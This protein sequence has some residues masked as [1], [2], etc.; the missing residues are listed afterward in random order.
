MK[1][2]FTILAICCIIST[3][4]SQFQF[5]S[6]IV[7]KPL[8]EFPDV[9]DLST[10]LNAGVTISYFLVNGIDYPWDNEM[11]KLYPEHKREKEINHR[12]V[13]ESVKQRLLNDT[14]K[15]V[16]VYKDSIA[17]MIKK[18]TSDYYLTWW[19]TYEDGRW[20][21]DGEDGCR[22][23]EYERERF[24]TNAP[25]ALARNHRSNELKI[26][27]TDTLSFV[28]YVKQHGTEPKEFLLETLSQ[29]PLVIYGEYHRRK[30][31][32]DLLSSLL[33]D[34]RFPEIVG[35]VF[36]EMP[37]Y[38]QDEFDRFYASEK[39]DTE[40]VLD[41]MRSF[42]INGWLDKGEYDFFVN[43]WKLNQTLP[44]E[45]RIR[46]VPTDEQPPWKLLNTKE[47][48]DKW[49]ENFMDRNTRMADVVENTL[50]TKTDRRNCLFVVGYGHAYKSHFPG[51]Q[52]TLKG[53]EPAL[54]AGAQ[55]AQR[56][57]GEKVFTI[58]QHTPIGN[59]NGYLPGL[60]RQGLF[61]YVFEINGN[62]PVAFP[63]VNSPFG[64]EPYDADY[65]MC[66]DR[67]VGNFEDNFDGYI[68]LQP[69]KDEEG[70]YILYEEI[71]SDTFVDE[72][73]RRLAFINRD[74][75]RWFGIEGEITKEKI[76]KVFK[77]DEGKKRWGYLFE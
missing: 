38:Q 63:L 14:I 24:N 5:Q 43:L 59:N 3:L 45:K 20:L 73:K 55:L 49:E 6:I 50:K 39:L 44:I 52:S 11:I 72:L 32:W 34:P 28:N 41:I 7:N 61:D 31:S 21:Y 53:Q 37:A 47:D 19:F 8:K 60:I 65:D 48:F 29:Y 46:V 62:K 12:V 16:M 17:F 10:P 70:D 77:E 18:T 66:F 40:I 15:E 33:T 4:H 69:L 30:V 13:E 27:S 54:S 58:F 64:A 36:V 25:N 67:R 26:V 22:S 57:S 68:F 76:I 23:L 71:W 75:N 35:T 9:Y 1:K 2:L 42:Q 56:L 74:I 51:L